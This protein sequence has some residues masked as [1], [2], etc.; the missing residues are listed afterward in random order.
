MERI[1]LGCDD[2][3]FAM[4]EK[5]KGYLQ[6][7]GIPVQ[8]MG[9]YQETDAESYADIAEKLCE[10]IQEG[11]FSRG[12]L[13]C[14]T[15]LGMSMAANK[16]Y[17]IRAAVC[18]DTY[19]AERATKSNQ[20]NVL[21]FGSRVVGFELA[22]KLIDAWYDSSFD[23]NSPSYPK[24]RKLYSLDERHLKRPEVNHI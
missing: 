18:S 12:I 22:Q 24:V 6:S 21:C 7:R 16:C 8:D 23:E 17:G 19:S 14:G 10:A 2:V 13:I 5:V 4:K 15:G 20:A 11:K 9:R 1:G 3:G